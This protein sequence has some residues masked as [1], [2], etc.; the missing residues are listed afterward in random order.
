M[1]TLICIS[2]FVLCASCSKSTLGF[3]PGSGTKP[4]AAEPGTGSTA[5]PASNN[6]Q[7][8]SAPSNQENPSNESGSPSGEWL[9]QRCISSKN[10]TPDLFGFTTAIEGDTI[11]VSAPWDRSSQNAITNGE[12]VTFD[13]TTALAGAVYVFHLTAGELVQQAYLKPA[14]DPARMDVFGMYG[15]AISGDIAVVGNNIHGGT[16]QLFVFRRS[17]ETW[18]QEAELQLH[19]SLM[20]AGDATSRL[21]SIDGDTLAVARLNGVEIY[22]RSGDT[23]TQEAAVEGFSPMSVGLSGDELIV[24]LPRDAAATGQ[25]ESETALIFLRDGTVW[26]QS[27]ILK[28]PNAFAGMNF[29]WNVAIEGDTAVVAAPWEMNAKTEIGDDH[30]MVIAGAV[31]VFRHVGEE[32]QFEAYLKAPAPASYSGFGMAIALF[33]DTIAAS[34][35]GTLLNPTFALVEV[36]KRKGS[37]WDHAKSLKFPSGAAI[38]SGLSGGTKGIVMGGDITGKQLSGM[39]TGSFCVF[40]P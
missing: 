5:G 27:A 25:S 28:A 36:F 17:G 30:S 34:W 33:G 8:K 9:Q 16:S 37:I 1:K 22:R 38:R 32:W 3:S 24:G 10:P 31:Y 15:L 23:W 14:I 6:T 4:A 18:S 35:K 26:N 2:L 13:A 7:Q 29:G 12:Q 20:A 19:G 40:Y 39:A 21:I 11:L